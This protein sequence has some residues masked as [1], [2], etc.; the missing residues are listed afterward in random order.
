MEVMDV[1]VNQKITIIQ[2]LSIPLSVVKNMSLGVQK[3]QPLPVQYHSLRLMILM[4]NKA[5]EFI[6]VFQ[7]HQTRLKKS[8]IHSFLNVSDF[9]CYIQ[10]SNE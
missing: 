2:S 1:G 10:K 3:S 5:Q 7:S 4:W 6:S 8:I 9:S